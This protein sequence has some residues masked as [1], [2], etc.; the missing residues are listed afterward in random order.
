MGF[1]VVVAVVIAAVS[2]A[3]VVVAIRFFKGITSALL[4]PMVFDWAC[5]QSK[6]ADVTAGFISET[7]FSASLIIGIVSSSCF[8]PLLLLSR[9][10]SGFSCWLSSL[11][12][13]NCWIRLPKVTSPSCACS[14]TS[15]LWVVSPGCS[16]SRGVTAMF[17]LSYNL[18]LIRNDL[19]S[20]NSIKYHS[21]ANYI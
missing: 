17:S 2:V 15:L 14:I 11:S 16:S 5:A 20:K 8:R 18:L 10:C 13:L 3:A 6:S 1:T 19:W 12:S 9:S 21:I 4:L 7:S